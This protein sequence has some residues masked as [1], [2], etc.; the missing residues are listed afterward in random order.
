MKKTAII[1]VFTFVALINYAQIS[2]KGY[3]IGEKYIGEKIILT[4]VGGEKGFIELSTQDDN[5]I[6]YLVF[7][8]SDEYGNQRY[9]S[10]YDKNKFKELIEKHYSISF[11][12]MHPELLEY[13]NTN[14]EIFYQSIKDGI[15]YLFVIGKD[16]YDEDKN[17]VMFGLGDKKAFDKFSEQENK[18]DANDF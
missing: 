8:P 9:L 18:S 11:K 13:E 14:S 6:F 15:H 5:T 2:L 16:K 4:S 1:L 7:V 12:A 3:T 10:N 17:I